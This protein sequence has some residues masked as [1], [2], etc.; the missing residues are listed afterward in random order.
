MLLKEQEK[1]FK[2]WFAEHSGLMFKIVRAYAVSP[3]DCDD[4]FQQILLGLW[5]SIPSFD[6]KAKETT[7]IYRVAL[8]TALVWKRGKSRRRKKR[9]L[10][11]ISADEM[12]KAQQS[13]AESIS[14]RQII[15]RLYAAIREL[16]KIDG[17]IIFMHL[18]GLSY[19]QMGEILG[20]SENNVGV[21]LNRAKK[22]LAKLLEGLIDDF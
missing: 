5:S 8:N 20:I 22:R 2:Q 14:R 12:P 7:W 11:T 6:G 13:P 4:L 3:D 10:L 19:Q 17:S 1:L 9:R 21:K 15:N 18:D 16:P